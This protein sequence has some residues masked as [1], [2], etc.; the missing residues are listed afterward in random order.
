MKVLIVGQSRS[1]KTS[2]AQKKALELAEG[3]PLY[4][5]AAMEPR[6]GEDLARIAR[7]RKDREGLGF[8][9]IERGSG[10]TAELPSVSP[11]GTVL[12]DS[13]TALLS[14]EL[15]APG[16]FKGE[17]AG[18]SRAFCEEAAAALLKERAEVCRK[19][20]SEAAARPRNFI[21]VADDIFRD[22]MRYDP[23]TESYRRLMGELL[24]YFA[25]ESDE[26]YECAAGIARCRKCRRRGEERA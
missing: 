1:G 3:G 14:N 21:L 20:L 12:F 9:T 6:D 13:L 10:L 18:E 26:V 5:W 15:F 8:T 24:Q 22:G 23:L 16:L 19:E 17:G 2:F 7:H 11:E 25:G 4:Y